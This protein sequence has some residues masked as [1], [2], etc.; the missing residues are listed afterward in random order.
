[1]VTIRHLEVVPWAIPLRVPLATARGPISY[2]H[3]FLVLLRAE[4]GFCGIGEA[5]PHPAAGPDALATTRRALAAAADWLVGAS[6][7]QLGSLLARVHGLALPAASGLDMAL[8]DLVG[9]VMGRPVT[10]LLGGRQRVAVPISALLDANDPAACACAARA[11]TARGFRHAK[12]KVGP[13]IEDAV[14][15]FGAAHEAAPTLRLR[16]DA[17]GAWDTSL[18]VAAARALRAHGLEWLEQPVGAG[19]VAVSYP[20]F[21][22]DLA[23]LSGA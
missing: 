1:M 3:G 18:A 13:A 8:H 15:R 19:D 23:R 11:A 4:R 14:A 17:N 6:T 21:W 20:G 22:D 12:L 2:R 16:A 7:T 10:E 5:A 9:R